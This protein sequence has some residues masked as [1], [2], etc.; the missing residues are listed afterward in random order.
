MPQKLAVGI[1]L[2]RAPRSLKSPAK[3]VRRM[4]NPRLITLTTDFGGHDWFVGTMKGVVHGIEP[5]ATII[6]LTHEISPGNIRAAAFALAA[7]YRFF[8]KG[9]VHVSVVDPGVGGRRR[10]IAVRSRKYF[11][12]GPDNGVL[13]WALAR[14]TVLSVHELK[15][16]AYFL[17]PVSHT[18]QGRDIFAPVA[19]HL[20]RRVPLNELG[21]AVNDFVRLDWPEPTKTSAGLRG[22]VLYI[23]RFGNAITNLD[24]RR[25]GDGKNWKVILLGKKVC[26]IVE[27][28][29]AVPPGRPLA[30]LGSSGFLELAVNG[31]NAARRL[32]IR[33]GETVL[34]S[35]L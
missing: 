15:N 28:Y 4:A 5:R 20:C 13:S 31:G 8:P 18:F 6:D 27:Y 33:V 11:F 1:R 22:E 32:R 34:V 21:P 17:N 26:R 19:A 25:L 10:A 24:A 9:T 3:Y 29:Q 7:S 30:V 35:P 23:D 14:E 12:V 16:S 2:S